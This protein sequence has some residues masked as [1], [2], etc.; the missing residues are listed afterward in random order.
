MGYQPKTPTLNGLV[1]GIFYITT[2]AQDL[3]KNLLD[4]TLANSLPNVEMRV[5]PEQE[6]TDISASGF[7]LAT[8]NLIGNSYEEIQQQANTLRRQLLKQP[9]LSPWN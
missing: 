9:E 5:T 1:G 8:V 7:P 3:A 6:I 2:F 4:F